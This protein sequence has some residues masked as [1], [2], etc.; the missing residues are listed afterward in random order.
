MAFI[1]LLFKQRVVITSI[2]QRSRGQDTYIFNR[3][4]LKA[5]SFTVCI[6]CGFVLCRALKAN[7]SRIQIKCL[8]TF[9]R[10]CF[11]KRNIFKVS[12]TYRL[13]YS[14]DIT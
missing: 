9:L 10:I 5:K 7:K 12:C 4:I 8:C 2:V 13:K 6:L 11:M 1:V 14:I 3:Y